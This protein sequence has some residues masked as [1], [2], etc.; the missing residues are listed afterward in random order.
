MK[1][2]RTTAQLTRLKMNTGQI[3]WLPKNPRQWDSDDLD[4]TV[5]SI[6]EDPDFLED[7]PLLAVENGKDLVV[8]GGNLRLSALRKTQYKTAPVVIYE[9]E[10]DE[11]RET[12][13]RRAMKDNGSFGSWDYDT[14]ANEWQDEVDKLADWGV[15]IPTEWA[16]GASV[17]GGIS[18][19]GPG[20]V[21]VAPENNLQEK[22]IVPPMS[23][24]DSRQGYWQERKNQWLA[25]LKDTERGES[26]EG[27]LGYGEA[28]RYHKQYRETRAFREE[29]G[30]SFAEWIEKYATE[31]DKAEMAKE[32]AA[33]GVS[34]FDPVLAECMCRW[35]LPEA[36]GSIVDPMAGDTRKGLV[37]GYCGYKFTGIE[38]RK[39]QVEA[40]ARMIEG[41]GLDIRYIC[42][43]GRNILNHLDQ[44]SQDL[45][46]CCPPYFDLEKYSN[47]SR[48]ASN[49]KSYDAFMDIIR[50]AF[51]DAWKTLKNNRFAVIVISDV[52]RKSDTAYNPIVADFIKMFEDFG[53]KYYNSLVFVEPLAGKIIAA[54]RNMTHRKV[55]RTH[56]NVLVFYKGDPR[57]IKNIYPEIDFSGIDTFTDEQREE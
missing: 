27:A 9:P 43:D 15:D 6:I 17:G 2:T 25:I 20:S 29:M 28:L 30:I 49:A 47:D 22:F 16:E 41:R 50:K 10:T 12:I 1:K 13:K 44:G 35:F 48:D 36:G 33:N 39:E 55:T 18:N 38:L 21:D 4:R 8:F 23:I 11:D 51:G 54:G 31:E 24:L 57:E 56:Q 46:F 3:D 53:G 42:D 32:V 40:N 19:G 5:A 26:R 7:R 34:L 52:R 37:F 45:F 14:L